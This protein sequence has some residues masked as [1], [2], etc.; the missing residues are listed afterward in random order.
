MS[1]RDFNNPTYLAHILIDIELG[2]GPSLGG[3]LVVAGR[4]GFVGL[5]LF[6]RPP[7]LFLHLPPLHFLL[8][9]H[10]FPFFRRHF[11][12]FLP[13]GF[14]FFGAFVGLGATR[15]GARGSS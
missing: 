2:T 12:F 14:L 15:M 13:F 11:L 9:L 4:A 7:L 3:G 6:L 5:G 1:H 8:R 10:L